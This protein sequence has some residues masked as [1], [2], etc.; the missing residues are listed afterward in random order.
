MSVGMKTIV[1][2]FNKDQCKSP[3]LR[4]K[5]ET[6]EGSWIVTI[7][8]VERCRYKSYINAKI[9]QNVILHKKLM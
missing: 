4:L 9:A 1:M 8:F 2:C 3:L 5:I 6:K 7:M